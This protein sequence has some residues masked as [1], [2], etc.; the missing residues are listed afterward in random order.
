MREDQK[1]AIVL[2]VLLVAG[3]KESGSGANPGGSDGAGA[4]SSETGGSVGGS[5]SGS[6]ATSV[7]GADAAASA[8]TGGASGSVGAAGNTA[9]GVGGAA[10]APGASIDFVE[11]IDAHVELF[12]QETNGAAFVN[13]GIVSDDGQVVA[14]VSYG[15]ASE[16]A[17]M[18]YLRE[19]FRWTRATG[20][21]PLGRLT[22]ET[23]L[24]EYVSEVD[25][26]TP[27]GSVI[28]GNAEDSEG[29]PQAYRWTE[30][31]AMVMLGVENPGGCLVSDDGST[32][33]I[34]QTT[35]S[36]AYRWN[37]DSGLEVLEPLGTDTTMLVRAISADGS[38]LYG[39]ESGAGVRQAVRWSTESGAEPLDLPDGYEDCDLLQRKVT[40][41]GLALLGACRSPQAAFVY[42][43]E[44]GAIG[45][46]LLD[47]YDSMLALGASRDG[48]VVLGHATNSDTDTSVAFRYSG[49]SGLLPLPTLMDQVSSTMWRARAGMAENG[50]AAIGSFTDSDGNSRA[51]RWDEA[52]G[53]VELLAPSGFVRPLVQGIS[54]DGDRV[55]GLARLEAGDSSFEAILWERGASS[56]PLASEL[57]AAGVD[58]GDV[59]LMEA[60]FFTPT[61]VIVG[62]A[63]RGMG[64]G[65][66]PM[67]LA[68]LP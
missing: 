41:H 48:D 37:A 58:V 49:E 25:D 36:S 2:G 62:T 24:N 65:H 23:E 39:Y 26:M 22:D 51:Y 67:F 47:G 35:N 15:I 46:G 7:G 16:V 32:V 33:A 63:R 19:A 31:A 59:T 13:E 27:D 1:W 57:A 34:S 43:E 30:E 8:S 20:T 14:G 38:V 54:P 17:P 55:V 18:V 68:D 29:I 52:S 64:L 21:V 42:T 5:S 61:G 45:L 6:S 11:P 10:G 53:S 60:S 44:N 4:T 40:S 28:V 56:I 12:E 3:C 50:S 9:G 66:R